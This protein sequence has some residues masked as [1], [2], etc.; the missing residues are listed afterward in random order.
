MV[1]WIGKV[2]MQV[3]GRLHSG[4]NAAAGYGAALARDPDPSILGL[5]R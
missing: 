2:W 1:I 4:M 5:G 3:F